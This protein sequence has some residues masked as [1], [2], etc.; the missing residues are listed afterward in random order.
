MFCEAKAREKDTREYSYLHMRYFINRL[1]I[2][3]YGSI[4]PT[5]TPKPVAVMH[6]AGD[7]ALVE[8][9]GDFGRRNVL[10]AS[11]LHFHAEAP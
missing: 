3:R 5:Q 10:T 9:V 1:N 4:P 7:S 8:R 2:H 6:T 11:S